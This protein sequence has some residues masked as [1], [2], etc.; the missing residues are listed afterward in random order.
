MLCISLCSL[1]CSPQP[2][3]SN[4]PNLQD[5]GKVTKYQKTFFFW[6]LT[7][8]F[9]E[10]QIQ[11][12][13][14]Y[15]L[16]MFFIAKNQVKSKEKKKDLTLQNLAGGKCIYGPANFIYARKKDVKCAKTPSKWVINIIITT[17]EN[18]HRYHSKKHLMDIIRQSKLLKYK[19][20]RVNYI[21]L[22]LIKNHYI[23]VSIITKRSTLLDRVSF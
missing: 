13:C 14:F 23:F 6:F 7:V 20:S 11:C 8:T 12:F 18:I 16:F 1:L 5:K 17:E 22:T 21:I 10:F 19:G 4:P 9:I 2:D 15:H 3:C